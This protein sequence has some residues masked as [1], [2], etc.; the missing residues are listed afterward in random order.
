MLRVPPYH[1]KT[2][3]LTLRVP[4]RSVLIFRRGRSIQTLAGFSH[5]NYPTQRVFCNFR[6]FRAIPRKTDFFSDQLCPAR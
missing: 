5:I 3:A 6:G 4:G 1:S 2:L